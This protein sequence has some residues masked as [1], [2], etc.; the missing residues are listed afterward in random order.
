MTNTQKTTTAITSPHAHTSDPSIHDPTWK[1]GKPI[2]KNPRNQRL[3]LTALRSF[4]VLI[5]LSYH[6]LP[7]QNT[8]EANAISPSTSTQKIMAAALIDKSTYIIESPRT[9]AG[10]SVVLSDYRVTNDIRL[11]KKAK[12]GRVL[13]EPPEVLPALSVLIIVQHSDRLPSEEKDYEES[14]PDNIVTN[15]PIF[16][17]FLSL[18]RV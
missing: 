8:K 11:S 7:S 9:R 12:S 14:S 17:T 18:K 13:H 6:L 3:K 16:I 4:S 1:M 2:D 15:H 5:S 10:Q